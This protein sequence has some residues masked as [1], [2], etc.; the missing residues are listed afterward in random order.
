MLVNEAM[1][2]PM[3]HPLLLFLF[4]LKRHFS[5][6][7]NKVRSIGKAENL[8]GRTAKIFEAKE[9]CQKQE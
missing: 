2:D 1:I 6:D 4:R 8:Y 7:F 3:S 5:L 9:T